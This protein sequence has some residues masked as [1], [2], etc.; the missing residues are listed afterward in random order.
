[1]NVQTAI[2]M[3]STQWEAHANPAK[4]AEMSAYMRHQFEFYGLQKND[5]VALTKPFLKAWAMDS[6]LSPQA[7][8]RAMWA[9]PQ[10]EWQY[11]ALMLLE[12]TLKTHQN[13]TDNELYEFLIINKSWWDTVDV[14]A[15]HLVGA[16]YQRFPD[17]GN[18]LIQRWRESDNFWL[19]RACVLFQL[20][21]KQ[22]TDLD[23][24]FELCQQWATSDE[25]FIQKAIGW[26]LR[27][28]AR[29]DGDAIRTFVAQHKL[30]A[31]S[32]REAL[33]HL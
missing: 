9:L 7:L 21:Y 2:A 19:H 26:A 22:K 11:T 33:K 10:R 3:L 1:M 31:L 28:Y 15:P 23:L 27:Q 13:T 5:R 17:E 25:F 12:K 4:A 29:V 32:K 24:L 6:E 30:A 8:A 14:V 20:T 18:I 16:Y